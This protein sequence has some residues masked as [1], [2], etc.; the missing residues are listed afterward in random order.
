MSQIIETDL[1]EVLAQINGK[2]DKLTEDANDI[3]VSLARL[4]EGQNGLSKR[5]DSLEFISRAVIGGI[6][7]ALLAGLVKFLFPIAALHIAL[8]GNLCPNG[9][10]Y[11]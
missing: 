4:E 7:V 9:Y 11:T 8:G 5:L 3:K 6:I 10:C 2:L 1:K